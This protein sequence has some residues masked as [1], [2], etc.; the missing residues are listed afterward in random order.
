M[1]RIPDVST[2]EWQKA[3]LDK[4]ILTPP[5]SP[6][7][8]DRYLIRGTG[9]GGWA[10][11]DNQIATWDGSAWE[12]VTPTGGKIVWVADES[13]FYLYKGSSWIL[14][15]DKKCRKTA[16]QTTNSTSFIDVTEMLIPVEA[17][18][19]IRYEMYIY[20]ENS[21]YLNVQITVPSN[22]VLH[23]SPVFH[24]ATVF[25]MVIIWGYLEN[26]VNAGNIQLQM[27]TILGAQT[28]GVLRGSHGIGDTYT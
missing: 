26:G 1:K 22:P 18:E 23:R 21:A 11:K 9:A 3:V 19:I 27:R 20:P 5:G 7:L 15:S 4:D 6:T 16:D 13:V 12:Y 17:N 2:F 28:V 14:F 24:I 8:G 10:G 25:S